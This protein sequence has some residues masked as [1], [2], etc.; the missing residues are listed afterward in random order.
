VGADGK[1]EEKNMGRVT[2]FS[3]CIVALVG[4]AGI[5]TPARGEPEDRPPSVESADTT[6]IDPD[7][8]ARIT[9]VVPVPNTISPEARALLAT[10]TAWAPAAGS[11]EQRVLIEKARALYPVTVEDA[12]IGG[13]PVRVVAPPTI[14]AG[15]RDRVL[16][17]LHGGGFVSDSGSMLESIPIASLTGTKVVT[18]LYRL[19]PQHRFPA[20]V[21]DVVMV[22]RKLLE[23][24][25]PQ[26]MALYGTSAG[27]ALSAESAVRFRQMGV[28]LPAAIGFFTGLAD[29]ADGGDSRAFFGVPGLSGAEA[30]RKGAK[31]EQAYI[32]DHD[33]K[34]PL[35]SP[36]HADLT[37]FP[38]TLCITGTRDLLLSD[39]A[40]F[41]RALLKAGVDARLV[42]FDA[43]PHAHWYMVGIP[44]ATEALELMARFFDSQLGRR[45][46]PR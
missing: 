20:A 14:A 35:V 28:P 46:L 11:D 3:S 40:N 43:M 23:T 41:H 5:A 42:V 21:D 16:I 18:V 39:T 25:E 2:T 7:G 13:V 45:D 12:V 37:G 17:N 4:I 36:I 19:A 26:R 15:K 38:P 31:P 6:S 44:E 22:Y 8:T 32:G 24:Y 10:G 27:A 9:R 33:P 29:F 30:P 1:E 34:D